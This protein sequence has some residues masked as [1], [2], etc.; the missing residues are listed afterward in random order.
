MTLTTFRDVPWNAP[1]YA[2]RGFAEVLDPSPGLAAV[3]DRERSLGL[4]AA[5]PRIVMRRTL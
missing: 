5:G 2:R 1:F 3:R 4:D